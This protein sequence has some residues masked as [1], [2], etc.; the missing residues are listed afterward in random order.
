MNKLL[1]GLI[2]GLLAGFTTS[3]A[4]ETADLKYG[5]YIH[6][7]M[8]TFSHAGEKGRL[9]VERF[10]PTSV[11]V[12]S[13]ARAAAQS[14][15]TFAVLTAKHES[16]FCL[17]ASQACDY[18]LA[19]SAFKGDLM[20]DF[21]AACKAEGIVPG[22]HYSIPD[23]Y[24]EGAVHFQG[25]VPP[26]YFKVIK[27]HVTELNTQY[28]ELRVF[29]LDISSRL[30]PD[31]FDEL[32]QIVKRLN[33]QCAVWATDKGGA[34]GPNH[35]SATVN[36][37]WM[38]SLKSPLTPAPQLFRTYQQCQSAGKAFVLNVGPLPSGTIPDDQLAVLKQMKNLIAH[39]PVVVPVVTAPAAPVPAAK[40]DAA[41]RL[42]KIKSLFDQGLI[43]KED[44]EKKVKEILDPL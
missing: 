28:P 38:W 8:D 30:S 21:I 6:Y 36:K 2:A 41:E 31:Q 3:A 34:S 9:P 39:P 13:W 37:S 10:A 32:S 33:P 29:I 40:P 5:L 15:M 7:G 4:A 23:A 43:S 44:Y 17:W 12:K 14:G 18:D 25:D 26:A 20:A 35:V 16:G 19:H 27:Q 24:N 1:F 22:M 42:K 11:N